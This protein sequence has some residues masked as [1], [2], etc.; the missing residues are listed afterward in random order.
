MQRQ[1]SD[2]PA[3]DMK[4][5]SVKFDDNIVACDREVTVDT[6]DGPPFG[7]G[8]P[9]LHHKC[10]KLRGELISR[11]DEL[12]SSRINYPICVGAR[13]RGRATA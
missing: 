10:H 13:G 6:V 1:L 9:Y 7:H 11:D 4:D 12:N 3:A 8:E 5:G 2:S